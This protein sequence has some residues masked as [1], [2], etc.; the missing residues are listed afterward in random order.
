M[1]QSDDR[2]KRHA[3]DAFGLD[4]TSDLLSQNIFRP[5]SPEK[6]SSPGFQ[7]MS[8]QIMAQM[9]GLDIPGIEPSTS[10]L[11]GYEWWPRSR[12]SLSPEEL[13]PSTSF[14]DG[15]GGHNSPPTLEEWLQSVNGGGTLPWPRGEYT[16][17]FGI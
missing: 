14:C 12:D 15:T 17:N 3:E 9:L 7:D 13:S 11:P 2:R 6:E 1:L 16:G 4:K 8:T 10:Y 5:K